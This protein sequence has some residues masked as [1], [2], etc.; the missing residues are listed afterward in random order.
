M[1]TDFAIQTSYVDDSL[2]NDINSSAEENDSK[3]LPT[4]VSLNAIILNLLHT[5]DI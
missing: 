5:E 3:S 2:A 4:Y 1:R